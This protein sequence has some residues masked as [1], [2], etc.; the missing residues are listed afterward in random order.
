MMQLLDIMLVQ[1]DKLAKLHVLQE[2]G[3]QRKG[4]HFVMMQMRGTI[5]L[6]PQ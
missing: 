6:E 5:L 4:N 3:R 1:P 2:H